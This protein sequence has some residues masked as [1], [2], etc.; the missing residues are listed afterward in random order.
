MS[1]ELHRPASIDEAVAQAGQLGESG[2]FLAGGT[3]VAIQMSR[4]RIDPAHLID[5][6]CLRELATI[7]EESDG[8]V[9]GALTTHKTIERYPAFGDVYLALAQAASVVGGHQVRNVAT[10]GGNI[11]NASPAADLVPVLQALDASVVLQSTV[12][13]RSVPIGQF[14]TGAG[15]TGR[16]AGELLTHIRFT[17][18]PR[19]SATFFLKAGRRRAMEISMVCVAAA[20]TL[21]ADGTTCKAVRLAIG[22]AAPTAYRAADAEKILIGKAATE[23]VLNEIGRLAADM[24]APIDDVRASADYRRILVARMSARVLAQCAER[25]RKASK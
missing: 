4:G 13:T 10:I 17:R 25:I 15:R 18:L 8:I 24:A 20:L 12:G 11:V 7:F 1:L 3:D 19:E 9:I 16:K 2:R 21:E 14:I 5:I 6:T 22:A 23:E